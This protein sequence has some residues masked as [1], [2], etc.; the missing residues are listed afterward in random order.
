MQNLSD[1]ILS[2]EHQL[3]RDET[4][5]FV[6]NEVTPEARERDS[7]GEEMS[8]DLIDQLGE[9]GFFGILI[10]EE[11]GG[12]GLDLKAYAVIAEELSRGWL[13]VGSII[14]RGQSLAGAT[15]EQKE[16]YLPKMASGELLKSIAISEPDAGSDVSN[17]RLR[18]EKDGDEYV[19]NGQKMWCTFAKGSD[20]ILTY[21]VT[22]PD[23]EP[24]YKG[25]SGFI[26][27]KPAGTFD[28]EGLSG[29]P[30]DKIGYHGW[31]TWEVNFDDVRVSADKLV[32]GEEGQG[33]Y[34]IME[35]F[36][37]GRV[38]TAARAVGLARASLED[39]LQYAQE[40]EQFDGPISDFQAIRFNLAEMATKVE[41]ARALS[42]LVAEAVDSGERAD[43]E[44]AM[45]KLFASEIAEEVTS[46]GIQIH[47][48]YGYTTEFDVER[49][50]RDA[51]LTRIFEGTSEIQKR[52]IA[53]DLLSS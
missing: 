4:K 53:D 17:M 10:D 9:M 33:F 46:E 1:V 13:S 50:W 28:R 14:A 43:A 44:A 6:D 19:L 31:K 42:L 21:A 48:G 16:E 39:S 22:D 11:Y 47:G 35:F 29:Q 49:Y 12:L 18:A 8:G 26:V 45:A 32:G 3:F 24:A 5:R 41:A 15:E 37:E 20:F 30:I 2:D 52:I 38:H 27:E 36:E 40:R 23:A 25:I 7:E 51:R 34:Q